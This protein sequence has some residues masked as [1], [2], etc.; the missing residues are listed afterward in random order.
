[1]ISIVRKVQQETGHL[2]VKDENTLLYSLEKQIFITIIFSRQQLSCNRSCFRRLQ[3]CEEL[4]D[5]L[6]KL[7]MSAF[8]TGTTQKMDFIS[9]RKFQ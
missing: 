8:N 6:E 4:K 2:P 3:S 5:W 1:M 9:S 7:I